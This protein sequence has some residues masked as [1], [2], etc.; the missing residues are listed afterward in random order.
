MTSRPNEAQTH[1]AQ[2]PGADSAMLIM[3]MINEFAFPG[4]AELMAHTRQM[5]PA[6]LALRERYDAAQRPV[7]YVNDNFDRWR[8]EFSELVE[9]CGRHDA[10]S[11]AVARKMAPLPTH[12]SILK[13]RHS[14]FYKTP[15]R[16][17]LDELHI[18]ALTIVGIAGDQ[19]VL[20][21]AM[22]AHLRDYA[23]WIPGNTV[24]SITA[25]R[26][27]RALSYLHE[28]QGACIENVGVEV[29]CPA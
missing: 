24:A 7:I 11:S 3:D 20:A 5:L 21:T 4:G 9:H 23:L 10:A 1:G 19:C 16:L 22:D 15:L 18:A 14:A 8:S 17:L 26:N 12:Y 2:T 13:P 6:V 28:V 25:A 29:H 27:Q